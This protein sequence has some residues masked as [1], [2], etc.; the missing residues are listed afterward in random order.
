MAD[1]AQRVVAREPPTRR[2]RPSLAGRLDDGA[3]AGGSRAHCRD[4]GSGQI[5]VVRDSVW[6]FEDVKE[7]YAKLAGLHASGKILVRVDE[8]VGDDEC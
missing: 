2:R 6:R 5:R 1:E 4:A 8:T 3:H 7:A